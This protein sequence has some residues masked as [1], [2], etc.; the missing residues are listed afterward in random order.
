MSGGQLTTRGQLMV[1]VDSYWWQNMADHDI[2]GYM[3][4]LA[5]V[6]GYWWIYVTG[7][8]MD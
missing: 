1:A 4:L 6:A 7:I 3:W 2:N 5:A 8:H